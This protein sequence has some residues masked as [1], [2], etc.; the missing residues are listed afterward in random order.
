[1]SNQSLLPNLTL[2]LFIGSWLICPLVFGITCTFT[3]YWPWQ[4]WWPNCYYLL[5]SAS[6][7][8]PKLIVN[9]TH[10]S[11]QCCV[12]KHYV[13]VTIAECH[14]TVISAIRVKV[15]NQLKWCWKAD[16]KQCGRMMS[17]SPS[18]RHSVALPVRE[19]G[20]NHLHPKCLNL[21]NF[22]LQSHNS[23]SNTQ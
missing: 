2:E 21:N 10:C 5:Q 1:M 8:P 16:K 15:Q 9:S 7:V 6:M 22:N 23:D 19:T 4:Q 13:R 12:I 18:S 20:Q 3:H 14:S 11:F 17:Q